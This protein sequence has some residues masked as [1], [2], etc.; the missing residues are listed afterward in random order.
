[1]AA[2]SGATHTSAVLGPDPGGD[3]QQAEPCSVPGLV[4]RREMGVVTDVGVDQPQ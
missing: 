1:M 3:P 2:Y 4:P